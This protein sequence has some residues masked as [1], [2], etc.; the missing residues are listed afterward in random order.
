MAEPA[1]APARTGSAREVV[2]G[3]SKP[4]QPTLALDHKLSGSARATREG[5]TKPAALRHGNAD[6]PAGPDPAE[7]REPSG[8]APLSPSQSAGLGLELPL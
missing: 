7:G 1:L 2:L 4:Q 3:T 6:T 8:N 5:V